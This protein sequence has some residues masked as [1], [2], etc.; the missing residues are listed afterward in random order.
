MI[1]FGANDSCL[2]ETTGQHIPL[3]QYK[4]NLKAIATHPSIQS[5]DGI[6]LI[7]V[8]PPPVEETILKTRFLKMGIDFETRTAETTKA[9]AD[10]TRTV[11]KELGITV[12]DLWAVFMERAG[13]KKE[14]DGEGEGEGGKSLP[15]PGSKKEPTNQV[16]AELLCDGT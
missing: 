2:P 14:T 6:R 5:H 12:L 16:L 3:E 15:L 10:V 9:Y 11:G 4:H 8:T 1:F 13:W 7:I